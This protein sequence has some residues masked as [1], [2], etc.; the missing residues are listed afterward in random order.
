MQSKNFLSYIFIF[1]TSSV[2]LTSCIIPWAVRP[3]FDFDPVAV[4]LKVKDQPSKQILLVDFTKNTK[5]K[6]NRPLGCIRAVKGTTPLITFSFKGTNKD[7]F[8]TEIKIC[9]GD[10]KPDPSDPGK[11]CPLA[12]AYGS[13]FAASKSGGSD[14]YP[15][16]ESNGA[17]DLTKISASLEE[18]VLIDHNLFEQNYFYIIKACKGEECIYTDPPIENEGGKH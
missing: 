14:W 17:I 1:L 18:F 6:E 4:N 13:Q 15:P 5:C 2:L 3:A 7:Y 16:D 11:A 9:L 8:F 12:N 10:V